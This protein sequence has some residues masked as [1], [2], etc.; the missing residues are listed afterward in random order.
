[1]SVRKRWLLSCLSPVAILVFLIV[2]FM[3]SFEIEEYSMKNKYRNREDI[4]KM[5]GV[6]FPQYKEEY[7]FLQGGR[8]SFN[9]DYAMIVNLKFSKNCDLTKFY[10]EFETLKAED[11]FHHIS[12]SDLKCSFS[13]IDDYTFFYLDVNKPDSTVV[14]KY[15]SW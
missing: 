12:S 15:G 13:R 2:I 14:L 10:K 5:I 11:P 6:E 8:V 3:F 1:M 7:R 9:G 4:G